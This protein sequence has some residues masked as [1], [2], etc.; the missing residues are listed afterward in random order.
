MKQP[1]SKEHPE[2][3]PPLT[4]ATIERV[5]E[6]LEAARDQEVDN[7]I[8]NAL[9]Q[10]TAIAENSPDDR[11][12]GGVRRLVLRSLIYT[13]FRVKIDYP[14]RIPKHPGIVVANHLNHIDP[15]LLLAELPGRPYYYTLGDARTLYNQ[16]WKRHI[17]RF[18]GGVIPLERLWKEEFAVIKA[19]KSGR[20]DLVD[21]AT[22][23][24]QDV[25]SGSAMQRLRQI[26]R[27]VQSI[28]AHQD[29]IILFPEG[30]LGK[31]EGRLHLPL[32]R[33]AAIYAL[34][35]GVPIVPVA[36]I[37]TKNLYLR[38]ELTLRFG[39]P[40][41]FSQSNRPKRG[42]VDRVLEE[43]KQALIAL[44][45]EDYQEPQGLKLLHYFLNHMFY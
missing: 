11:I 1:L 39:Q 25:P 33:G 45:P 6:G 4:T 14:D 5:K 18:S 3:L 40:L 27:A 7:Q 44:L 31:T 20:Q 43:I 19:A 37:G 17:L 30:R 23:I 9:Q 13:L 42:E 8:Q 34:R 28:L 29:G 36:L 22:E 26:E 15:L 2:L 35:A 21:L 24:E 12:S 38:K 41:H 10:T 32:K 16:G